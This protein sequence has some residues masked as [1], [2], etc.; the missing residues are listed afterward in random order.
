MVAFLGPVFFAVVDGLA[1]PLV[2]RPD[3]VLPSTF[4][5][6]TTAG[7]CSERSVNGVACTIQGLHTAGVLRLLAVFALGL[8]AAAFLAAGAFLVSGALVAVFLGAPRFLGVAAL[9]VASLSFYMNINC[10][11]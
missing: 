10:H 6:S 5:C 8:E 4:S 7:A 11:P 1:G 2:I 9:E 3:L